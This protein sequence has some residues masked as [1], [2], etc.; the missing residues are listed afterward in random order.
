[1]VTKIC[2]HCKSEYTPQPK[3][4]PQGEEKAKIEREKI[5]RQVLIQ[6]KR[7]LKQQ[8]K[9]WSGSKLSNEYLQLLEDFYKLYN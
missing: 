9:T 5:E 8:I 3:P 7:E 6:K 1:M 2:G 4:E